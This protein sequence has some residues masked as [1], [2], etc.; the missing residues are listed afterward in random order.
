M[1][2]CLSLA[3]MP[4]NPSLVDMVDA[5]LP[6]LYFKIL[7]MYDTRLQQLSSVVVSQCHLF[8]WPSYCSTIIFY[9]I[10]NFPFITVQK[11]RDQLS[12]T[13]LS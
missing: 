8:T 7:G 4:Y 1:V 2:A 5:D 6:E 9:M 13:I 3:V 10:V 12:L 11:N